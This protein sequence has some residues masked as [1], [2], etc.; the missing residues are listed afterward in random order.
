MAIWDVR[1]GDVNTGNTVE[2]ETH[3][4]AL[5]AAR[6]KNPGVPGL[7]VFRRT[8]ATNVDTNPGKRSGRST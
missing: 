1:S 5:V 7:G 6:A 2:A 3:Q 4:E 8:E